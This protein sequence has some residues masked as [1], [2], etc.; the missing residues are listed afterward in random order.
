MAANEMADLAAAAK[1]GRP[2]AAPA[3]YALGRVHEREG[4]WDA[5]FDAWAAGA[6]LKR[7]EFG[8]AVAA[9]DAAESDTVA[10]A[11]KLFSA[12]FV[13]H[14]AGAGSTLATPIFVI[15][16]PRSGTT[17]VE[18]ILASHPKVQGMGES[19]VLHGVLAG[20]YPYDALAPAGP[21]H[22]RRL[23]DAYLRSMRARGW[24]NNARFVDK[25]PSSLWAVGA[26]HLMF[27][28]A[29]I[30]HTVRKL[31]DTAVSNFSQLYET[32]NALSYD[33]GDIGRQYRRYRQIMD[34]WTAVLPP[35]RIVEVR[36]E[37]LVADPEARIR[38]LVTEA[39]GLAW[40]PACLKF[41]DN[42]RAVLTAS[43]SQVRRPIFSSS[44]GRWRR[45]ERHLGPL[46]AALGDSSPA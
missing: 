3:A 19:A 8:D 40:D 12:D 42:P 6:A 34:H 38:W 39:C 10:R 31:A 2:H 30:L 21:D 36:L 20:Q 43:A 9:E 18:Q 45:Y 1:A 41:Y 35:G 44:T 28:R 33:L 17:L 25:T 14:H 5:A 26:I 15:G 11:M 37:D 23:A 46:F 7:A 24:G 29:V 4:R 32:G 22:F 16:L 13:A 27:P